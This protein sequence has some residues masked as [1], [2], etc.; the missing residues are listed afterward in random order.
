MEKLLQM[1]NQLIQQIEVQSMKVESVQWYLLNNL[2]R[3]KDVAENNP[4]RHDIENEGRA[5]SRFCVDSMDWGDDLFRA[6]TAITEEVR[7]AISS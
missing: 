7:H 2:K 4:S 5:L 6:A 1:I 3:F